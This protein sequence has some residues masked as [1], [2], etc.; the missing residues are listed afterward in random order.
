[1]PKP[2]LALLL[3]LAACGPSPV[4]DIDE[5][6][7]D[8]MPTSIFRN[9]GR[10]TTLQPQSSA[11]NSIDVTTEDE[12]RAALTS[13]PRGED[14]CSG[15]SIVITADIPVRDTIVL[16]VQH[17]GITI[18]SPGGAR[19]LSVDGATD[20]LFAVDGDPE[21]VT[22][23]GFGL[24][25][26]SALLD[27]GDSSLSTWFILNVVDPTQA[28]SIVGGAGVLTASTISGVYL[29]QIAI[30]LSVSRVTASTVNAMP[31]GD[32]ALNTITGNIV[33][34]GD[35]TLTSGGGLNAISSNVF[36]SGNIDTSTGIGDN[37]IVGNIMQGGTIT[38]TGTDAVTSN[39]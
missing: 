17:S 36:A 12:L 21:R 30:V 25:G 11:Q 1:M 14:F 34:G 23:I 27:A 8:D 19:F 20:T 9:V 26:F 28:A 35:L 7:E 16:G 29:N 15:R 33:I 37:A 4:D 31:L 13:L 2:A 10:R 3:C 24:T 32:S 22:L 6:A 38:A 18:T 5:N 39:T